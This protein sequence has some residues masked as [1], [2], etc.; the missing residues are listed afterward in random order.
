MD[1]FKANQL[2][3]NLSKTVVLH[4][5]DHKDVGHLTIDGTE[6]PLVNNT[7]FLGVHLNNQIT[8]TTHIDHIHKN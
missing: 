6:I 8:W 2:S 3:L 7:K 4:F 5:R 1:W